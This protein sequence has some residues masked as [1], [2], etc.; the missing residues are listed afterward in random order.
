MCE[1]GGAGL[2]QSPAPLLVAQGEHVFANAQRVGMGAATT[3]E[4][5]EGS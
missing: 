2:G 1:V 3:A 4:I 5:G